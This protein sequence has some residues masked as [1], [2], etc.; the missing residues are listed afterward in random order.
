M[1]DKQVS[2]LGN[3]VRDMMQNVMETSLKQPIQSGELRKNPVEPAWICPAGYEYEIVETEHFLMEYL[4]PEGIYTG[5]VILQLHGGGYIGPMKNIYRRFAVRYSKLSFGGDVLTIDYR[6]APEDP[7]PAALEDAVFAY[8]W[9]I[10]EK[11]Y[12]PD[13]IIVAGDSAGGGLALA[14]G[15]YLRDHRLPLPGGIITMSPWTDLTNSGKSYQDNYETDPL[16]GNSTDNM[17]YHSSYIGEA[18]PT[19]PYLSPLFGEY[20]GFPPVLMQVGSYEVLLSDTIGVAKQLKK[21]GVRHRTSVYEGMFHVFQMGLDLIPESREAWE[22]VESF[23]RIVYG[24]SRKP[25]GK[26]VKKVK[27]RRR[28]SAQK[29][30]GK[31]L[32][33]IR[34]NLPA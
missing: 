8:K 10:Q 2:V 27:T 18:D 19:D 34:K 4:R 30:A 3:L 22:E 20:R 14:L 29:A 6:V 32:S 1:R 26:V 28:S 24:I 13:H 25:E 17:L 12:E 9:L 7:Y 23:L 31:V 33:A 15:L 11:E 5:R 21:A 16:F